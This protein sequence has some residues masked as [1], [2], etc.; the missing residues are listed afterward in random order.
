M[1]EKIPDLPPIVGDGDAWDAEAARS[2]I[3]IKLAELIAVLGRELPSSLKDIQLGQWKATENSDD[4]ADHS[5]A[6]D[7]LRKDKQRI[8]NLATAEVALEGFEDQLVLD[9]VAPPG[10]T[11]LGP[12]VALYDGLR[13][14][15]GWIW[16]AI[17]L[18]GKSIVRGVQGKF[19][20]AIFLAEMMLIIA[21]T[22]LLIDITKARRANRKSLEFYAEWLRRSALPQRITG[23]HRVKRQT[24]D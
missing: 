11:I 9:L 10:D 13:E 19:G 4:S 18:I 23:R 3:V 24:R 14:Y 20:T 1:A 17:K 21:T 22:V 12:F 5:Y 7:D 6:D 8:V 15:R 2:K 16:E